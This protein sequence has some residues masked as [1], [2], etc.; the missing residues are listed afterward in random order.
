MKKR[1]KEQSTNILKNYLPEHCSKW[2]EERGIGVAMDPYRRDDPERLY[3]RDRQ[4]TPFTSQEAQ[5][6]LSRLAQFAGRLTFRRTANSKISVSWENRGL[7]PPERIA[8]QRKGLWSPTPEHWP[9]SARAEFP[10]GTP[11]PIFQTIQSIRR[12]LGSAEEWDRVNEV[13]RQAILDPNGV[14][15]NPDDADDVG[16][17]NFERLSKL[18]RC[19]EVLKTY[20]KPPSTREPGSLTGEWLQAE[21]AM[22]ALASVAEDV[23]GVPTVAEVRQRLFDNGVQVDSSR[24]NELLCE[25]GFAW[26]PDDNEAKGRRGFGE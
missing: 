13:L 14:T 5:R 2:D 25:I 12:S 16:L 6:Y 21:R 9:P 22:G 17:T 4:R 10:W 11:I 20:E 1:P 24:M 23:G 15:E 8:L 26:L 3:H 18:V 19:L 7:P